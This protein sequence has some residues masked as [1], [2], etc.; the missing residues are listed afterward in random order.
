LAAT[1]TTERVYEAFL[2]EPG[3]RRTFYHGHTYSGNPL[4]CAAAL[5]SLR[6]FEEQKTLERMRPV[7]HAFGNELTAVYELPWVGEIRMRGLMV[8]IELVLDQE[9]NRPFAPELR[10]GRRAVLEARKRGVILRPLGDVVVLMP[11]LSITMDEMAL[12]VE[13][14]RSSIEAACK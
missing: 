6:I 13:V 5:A 9:S 11:P 8:G 10:M 2:G 12:L 7:V 14:T 4:G 3:E 1:L